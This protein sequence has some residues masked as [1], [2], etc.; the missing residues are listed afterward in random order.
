MAGR[1]RAD[2]PYRDRR[3]E[4][5]EARYRKRLKEGFATATFDGQP[6]TETLQCRD[7]TDQIRWVGLLLKCQAASALGAGA[8]P[9]DPPIRCT[10]NREYAVS[11]DD[12]QARMWAL[13]AAYA[14]SL[15]TLWRLK[16]AI[17]SA[18]TLAALNAV[19][20]EEGWP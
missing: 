7:E 10:S 3:L 11:H 16:D 14:A 6:E 8:E 15:K 20:L 4:E 2:S 18:P 5:L 1:L 9:I 17:R 19:D 13:L 12:A